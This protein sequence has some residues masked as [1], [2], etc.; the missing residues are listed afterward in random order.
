MNDQHQIKPFRVQDSVGTSSTLFP[1]CSDSIENHSELEGQEL[2]PSALSPPAANYQY[3][4][5]LFRLSV[6][7]FFLAKTDSTF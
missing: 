2:L 5:S 1:A 3:D 6:I 4:Y 7:S